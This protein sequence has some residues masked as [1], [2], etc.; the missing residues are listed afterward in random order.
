MAFLRNEPGSDIVQAAL[1]SA[2][3]STVNLS[4]VLAKAAELSKNFDAVKPALRGLQLR[5]VPFD[6]QQAEIAASLRPVTR[7]LGLSLG[8]RCCLALGIVEELP[9][10][11]TDRDW[12][13]L[14]LDIEIN[15]I[16]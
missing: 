16:R 15:V 3:I 5:V 14:Q 8:D 6:E 2:T 1:V 7:S 13:K 9:V 11:T 10:M 4:E 12:A